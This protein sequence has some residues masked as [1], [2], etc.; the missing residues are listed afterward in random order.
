ME[1]ARRDR[2]LT[3]LGVVRYRPRPP[4]RA[5]AAPPDA[6]AGSAIE[7]LVA[8]ERP[9]ALLAQWPP[10][11]S[12]CPAPLPVVPPPVAPGSMAPG[13]PAGDAEQLLPPLRLACWRPAPDLLVLDAQPPGGLPNRDQLTLL[14][15][16]LA[17]IGRRPATLSAAEFIDWPLLPGGDCFLTA[18][19]EALALFLRGRQSQS[20]FAWLLVLGEPAWRFFADAARAGQLLAVA[21][22]AVQAIL[23]PGLAEMLAN[24][25]CKAQ[26]WQAIRFLVAERE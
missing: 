20:S 17:A 4:A 6:P 9:A 26:T 14:G 5:V 10:S 7:V 25:A 21:G 24:P 18:A 3:A 2:Y 23:A 19:R 22:G 15:N 13:A 12:P 16:I 8:P 11:E 1:Q